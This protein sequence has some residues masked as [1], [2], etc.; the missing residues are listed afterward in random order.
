MPDLVDGRT[1]V[2]REKESKTTI[3]VRCLGVRKQVDR[4]LKV[5]VAAKEVISS[6]A[7]MGSDPCWNTL[8][9]TLRTPPCESNNTSA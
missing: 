8:G 4:I 1:A 9:W 3:R 2:M 7:N 6:M 5:V